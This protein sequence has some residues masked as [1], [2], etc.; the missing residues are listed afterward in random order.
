MLRELI[1][2]APVIDR[3]YPLSATAEAIGYVGARQ[4]Q[5]KTVITV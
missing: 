2:A 3:T 5:G 1:E 4:T